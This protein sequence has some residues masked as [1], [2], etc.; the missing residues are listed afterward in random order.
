MGRVPNLILGLLLASASLVGCGGSND[1][2]TEDEIAITT[3][4]NLTKSRF[5]KQAEEICIKG[6]QPILPRLMD[7]EE[8]NKAATKAG[9]V[10]VFGA[11]IKAIIPPAVQKQI[12]RIR[13]LGAPPGDEEEIEAFLVALEADIDAIENGAA[14]KSPDQLDGK[15]RSSGRLASA[16]GIEACAYG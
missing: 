4:P 9:D 5:V 7:F 16:Y 6:T 11:G 12:D 3:A 14:L 8:E 15:F 13:A 2:S 10:R 1:G